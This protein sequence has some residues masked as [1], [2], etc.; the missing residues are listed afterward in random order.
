MIGCLGAMKHLIPSGSCASMIHNSSLRSLITD[1]SSF[2]SVPLCAVC[3]LYS[4]FSVSDETNK[5]SCESASGTQQHICKIPRHGTLRK[6]VPPADE[7]LHNRFP[8]TLFESI[9]ASTQQAVRAFSPVS[10]TVHERCAGDFNSNEDETMRP[11]TLMKEVSMEPESRK[12]I[13]DLAA[14]RK[15]MAILVV[16]M[17]EEVEILRRPK[18]KFKA[19]LPR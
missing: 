7:D 9:S 17:Q 13:R 16:R 3:A 5:L 15:R 4:A 11:P 6:V 10:K 18:G 14:D 1:T 12:L 2:L 8:V 19:I